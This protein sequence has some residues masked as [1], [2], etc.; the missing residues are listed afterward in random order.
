[1]DK[2]FT[3]IDPTNQ[4]LAFKVFPF[5]DNHH[6][7]H[8]QR[9]SYYTVLLVSEG[10]GALKSDFSEYGF[11]GNG[12]GSLM[13]FTPYQPFMITAQEVFSGI[14]MHFHPDFFCVH[15]HQKEVACNGILF[16]NVYQP[17][18][19]SL[20]PAE[21]SQLRSLIGRMQDEMAAGGLAQYELLVSYLKIFLITATRM[22]AS[23]S[24]DPGGSA[25]SYAEPF[26]LQG[27][28]TAIESHFKTMHRPGE[29]SDMLNISTKALAKIAK[30]HFH[31]TLTELISERIVIEAKRE[32]YLT[33]KPIKVIAG[34][35]GFDDEYYFSRFFKTNAAVSP[36]MFRDT[37]GSARAES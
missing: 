33:S 8:L 28:K 4:N 7:D 3:L 9:L 13:C 16:N 26:V 36:Q 18:F 5:A 10:Q 37:V 15:K 6:F 35:L 1:M 24:P 17:P 11:G 14:A 2:A 29:Y 27:L 22:K 34:E 23:R 30:I 31:K 21:T 20:Q 12:L 25:A 19:L 32:L